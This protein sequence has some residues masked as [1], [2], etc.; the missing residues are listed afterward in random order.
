MFGNPGRV[1]SKPRSSTEHPFMFKLSSACCRVSLVWHTQKWKKYRLT[2]RQLEKSDGELKYWNDT[3]IFFL[4]LLRKMCSSCYQFCWWRTILSADDGDF[5]RQMVSCSWDG[6]RVRG[7]VFK[8][9]VQVVFWVNRQWKVILP[10]C[11]DGVLYLWSVLLQPF[12]LADDILQVLDGL[13]HTGVN[14]HQVMGA[15]RQ[16]MPQH[17]LIKWQPQ[18]QVQLAKRVGRAFDEVS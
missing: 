10:K 2:T 1:K 6:H 15:Y 14:V 4:K 9:R 17:P 8:S 11:E 12:L 18:G 7:D 16:L 3:G 5:I 13:G